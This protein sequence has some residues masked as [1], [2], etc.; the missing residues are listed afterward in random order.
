VAE[1]RS[2]AVRGSVE[3]EKGSYPEVADGEEKEG[4]RKKKKKQRRILKKSSI[5]FF[6]LPSG[7]EKDAKGKTPCAQ[8]RGGGGGKKKKKEKAARPSVLIALDH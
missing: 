3:K 5:T 2:R 6:L 4:K 7:K 1:S 8:G